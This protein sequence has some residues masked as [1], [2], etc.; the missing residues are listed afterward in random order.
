MKGTICKFR[1]NCE[2]FGEEKTGVI[3]KLLE[4]EK[5]DKN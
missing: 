3:I 1:F 2:A 4:G 5:N